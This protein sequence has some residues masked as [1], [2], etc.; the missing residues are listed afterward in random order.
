MRRAI[1]E[2]VGSLALE[3]RRAQEAT[4]ADA[5]P[6]L[7]GWSGSRTILLYVSAFADEVDTRPFLT[8]ALDAGT[9]LVLPRVDRA[10]RRLRLHR[11]ADP[12]TDLEP[13]VLGILEPV[14]VLPEVRAEAIDWAL[15]PGVAF[16]ERG[17]RLGRGAGHYDRL[18]PELRPDCTC[19]SVCLSAQLVTRLPVEP[20]DVPVDGVT[21]PDRAIRGIGRPGGL[22][23]PGPGG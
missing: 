13:G 3:I 16:D 7:P 4:I 2:A 11:V 5:F 19:W 6:R 8:M 9:S 23:V 1:L 17:Y 15:V 14:A 18:L 12:R 21:A 10:G 20:H 22:R